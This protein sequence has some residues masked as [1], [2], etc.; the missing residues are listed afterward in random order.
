MAEIVQ[1]NCDYK[2]K[3][4][5]RFIMKYTY[6]YEIKYQEVD[7][8]H[9]LRLYVLENYLL[10]VA[11]HIADELGFGIRYFFPKGF[12][13]ILTRMSLEME[14]LPTHREKII[15]ET[16]IESNAHLIS[17]RDFRI[18]LRKEN[19]ELQQIGQCKSQWAVLD[20][21]KRTIANVFDDEVFAGHIDGEVLEMSRPARMSAIQEPTGIAPHIVQFSDVDYNNHCNS[22]KYLERM[23]DAY[24]PDWYDKRVRLDIQ[25]QH[26]QRLGGVLDTYYLVTPDGVQYQQKDESG[27]ICCSA[28]ITISNP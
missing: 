27:T 12:T 28:R 15:I 20:I 18:Y 23:I 17:T 5:R 14:M 19:G 13:W 22:C 11:G 1:A 2:L 8:N 7:A 16:W 10:E 3:T 4:Y 9:R 26:E 24:R 21:Q 6:D 25:Y